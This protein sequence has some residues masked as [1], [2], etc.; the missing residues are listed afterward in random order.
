MVAIATIVAVLAATEWVQGI[1]LSRLVRRAE[2]Q[3]E[4]ATAIS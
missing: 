2:R 4:R 1:G 3:R